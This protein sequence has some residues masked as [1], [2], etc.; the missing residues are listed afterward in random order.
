LTDSIL[1]QVDSSAIPANFVIYDSL[2]CLGDT[3]KFL[4]TG[5]GPDVTVSW[6]PAY[7]LALLGDT[8]ACVFPA[9]DTTYYVTL[10]DTTSGCTWTDSVFV[11]VNLLPLNFAIVPGDTTVCFGDSL[12]FGVNNPG[13]I[14]SWS[15]G[16][17]TPTTSQS[18]LGSGQLDVMVF[19]PWGSAG[20]FAFDTVMVTVDSLALTAQLLSGN[21]TICYG[22][23]L[24]LLA[25][26]AS[27]YAWT[28]STF[29]L[30]PGTSSPLAFPI[31]TTTYSVLMGSAFCSEQ[32]SLE[33][34]VDSAG[35]SVTLSASDSLACIG[36]TVSLIATGGGTYSW[37][38]TAGGNISGAG[39][40]VQGVPSGTATYYLSVS[41]GGVCTSE[42]TV[43]VED[44]SCCYV[45]N[46]DYVLHNATSSDLYGL[47]GCF[48]TCDTL[49]IHI[50]DTFRVNGLMSFLNCEIF[51]DSMAVIWIEPGQT[52]NLDS[53]TVQAA[54]NYMWDGIY[55]ADSTATLNVNN[56]NTISD[57]LFALRSLAGGDIFVTNSLFRD[58]F[59]SIRVDKYGGN[60]PATIRGNRFTSNYYQMLP[61]YSNQFSD[62][63]IWIMDVADIDIGVPSGLSYRNQFD[64][65]GIGIFSS[66]S[67]ISVRN[68]LFRDILP[69]GPTKPATLSTDGKGTAI[70]AAGQ[71]SYEPDTFFT[72]KIGDNE[73]ARNL[74]ERT[75]N[76]VKVR[77]NIRLDC[78][79]NTFTD[80]PVVGVLALECHGDSLYIGKNDFTNPWIGIRGIYNYYA[81]VTVEQDTFNGDASHPGVGIWLDD[82]NFFGQS[83][84][85]GYLV[86]DNYLDLYGYGIGSNGCNNL[87]IDENEIHIRGKHP[88]Y[89]AGAGIVCAGSD[90][91]F[92][93]QNEVRGYGPL[94]DELDGIR[95]DLSPE[96][97]VKCNEIFNFRNDL[98]FFGP[99]D[100]AE[101]RENTFVGGL[102]GMVH[103]NNGI[104][105]TQGDATHPAGNRWYS[106]I[107]GQGWACGSGG[108]FM[109]LAIN[110][111]LGNQNVYVRNTPEQNPAPP[112]NLGCLGGNLTNYYQTA[113]GTYVIPCGPTSSGNPGSNRVSTLKRIAQKA[114][115][116]A[117]DSAMTRYLEEQLA[118]AYFEGDTTLASGDS[119][120][121]AFYNDLKS[122]NRFEIQKTQ[123]K[124][125]QMKY[126]EALTSNQFSPKN[127]VEYN[128]LMATKYLAKWETEGIVEKPDSVTLY[129]IATQCAINGGKG[130]YQA[131][132]LLGL[133]DPSLIYL[134]QNC[135]VSASKSAEGSAGIVSSRIVRFHPNPA[136]THVKASSPL[137]GRISMYNLNGVRVGE[138][139]VAVGLNTLEWNSLPRGVYL[140]RYI[141]VDGSAG[142]A[143]IVLQ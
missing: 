124:L 112:Y 52:L 32:D 48:N 45:P 60:H 76:G 41:D 103:E 55:V 94:T 108:V 141:L 123:E 56:G 10:T 69:T 30:N 135:L 128:H 51:M 119:L 50:I 43:T 116:Y 85:G 25:A 142:V 5:I 67:N 120:L 133:V 134:D 90:S 122:G 42:D 58:N 125:S 96:V 136:S 40:T 100:T 118:L 11:D 28:P 31:A 71:A 4:V 143:R 62:A 88:T 57:G 84:P 113:T 20:C 35:P 75:T 93:T 66:G 140:F 27:T 132:V 117:F 15:N 121:A 99:S 37:T 79:R 12:T 109:T 86:Q 137:P 126:S 26:G 7:N 59:V 1:V 82:L 13:T 78:R 91:A 21:D 104:I 8:L 2:V 53:C 39:A 87:V 83:T 92:V 24:Q 97:H 49:R 44:G 74:F 101:V 54:C 38:S 19:E 115:S 129:D 106:G 22:D 17:G 16:D 46:A 64:T 89:K 72:V 130:V 47:A 105:G 107:P 63:G 70:Y 68:N 23:S 77:H 127:K 131:R 98:R 95:V 65:L 80:I 33:I 81:H 138:W 61:P 29:L 73:A 36:D 102:R 18:W 6:L 139:D 110:T 9:V 114:G 14:Y 111:N 3:A 34:S